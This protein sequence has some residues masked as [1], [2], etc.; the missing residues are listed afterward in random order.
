ASLYVTA[1]Q[2]ATSGEKVFMVTVETSG[3][4]KQIALTANVIESQTQTQNPS[5]D[6]S[7]LRQGLIIGLIVLVV[8]LVILGLVVGFGKMKGKEPE[9]VSGQTYY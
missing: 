5:M 2:D 9:E 3:D 7:N 6:L 4:K 8:L 1:K